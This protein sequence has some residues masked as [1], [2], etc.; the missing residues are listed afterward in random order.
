MAA[1]AGVLAVVAWNM[2]EKHA[3]WRL[4]N[5]SK[6]DAA[7]LLATFGL[8]VFRDLTE[9]IIVGFALGAAL[10]IQR[11]SQAATVE[12]GAPLVRPDEA[13]DLRASRAL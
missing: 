13:D 8:T 7:V 2:F 3:F 12:L 1:L 4:L 9:A 5:A 6:G 10:F 11:M